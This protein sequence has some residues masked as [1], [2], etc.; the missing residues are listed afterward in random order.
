MYRIIS[1]ILM[2]A[3]CG[4]ASAQSMYK[5]TVNGKITYTGAPCTSGQMKVVIVPDLPESD[6]GR[7]KGLR[8]EKFALD[9][10]EKARAAR[11]STEVATAG[12]GTLASNDARCAKLRLEVQ[13]A[14]RNAERAP[15]FKKASMRET[16]ARMGEAVKTECGA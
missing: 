13:L 6:P 14:T 3:A 7:E 12:L 15:G 11:E 5:C 10:L 9:K 4:A 16:A 8:R 2:V 1:L